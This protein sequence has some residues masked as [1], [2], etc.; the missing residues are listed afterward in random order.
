MDFMDSICQKNHASPS[1]TPQKEALSHCSVGYNVVLYL[2]VLNTCVNC[3]KIHGL[4]Y[5]YPMF[6]V[7]YLFWKYLTKQT[8]SQ[9]ITV[10]TDDVE[11][12][13]TSGFR[14]WVW[15]I[16]LLMSKMSV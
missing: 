4:L 14:R 15:T 2:L 5:I 7:S 8:V 3:C 9:A 12:H 13:L 6:S 11:L 16:A 10:V 1:P